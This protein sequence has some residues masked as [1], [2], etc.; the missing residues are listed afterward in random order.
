MGTTASPHRELWSG[1]R[2]VGLRIEDGE[3][4]TTAGTLTGVATD[5]DGKQYLVTNQHVIVGWNEGQPRSGRATRL[6]RSYREQT[7]REEL[8]QGYRAVGRTP[9]THVVS[10]LDIGMVEVPSVQALPRLHDAA[11]SARYIARGA[12][13]PNLEMNNLIFLGQR[14]DEKRVKIRAIGSTLSIAGRRFTGLVQIESLDGSTVA[15]SGDSGA[16]VFRKVKDGVYQLVCVLFAG[17]TETG[18]SDHHIAHAV[19]ATRVEEKLK[20]RFGKRPPIAR[21]KATPSTVVVGQQ[22]TLDASESIDHDRDPLTYQ[23][24]EE[25]PENTAGV[26]LINAESAKATFT[27][28]TTPTNLTFYLTVRN[29]VGEY[30]AAS[31]SVE[32]KAG[33]RA[34]PPTPTAPPD[35]VVTPEENGADETGDNAPEEWSDWIVMGGVYK[36]EGKDR[37][38][39]KI[40]TSTKA[41]LKVCWFPCPD[42]TATEEEEDDDNGDDDDNGTDDND[43]GTATTTTTTVIPPGNGNGDDDNGDGNGDDN[44]NGNG[45]PPR[46]PVRTRWKPTGTYRGTGTDRERQESRTVDGVPE[47]RWISDPDELLGQQ[48]VPVGTRPRG[49]M[50]QLVEDG[51]DQVQR[52]EP[53]GRGAQE[54]QSPQHADPVGV[55]P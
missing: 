33:T 17:P 47:Y 34:R 31:V 53:R 9:T 6:S 39:K 27:A 44:D 23:W 36:G 48:A 50:G 11:H 2:V 26:T 37:K 52:R 29:A 15:Q 38:C 3:R 43:N 21:A 25:T 55:R 24:A 8:Y 18:S 30:S 20:V 35:T 19:R 40:K 46:E 45:T 10:D 1:I 22:V 41:G 4:T 14:T 51:Q 42:D 54:K 49:S 12:V 16:P 13:E 28:P 7:G 5:E 32:V